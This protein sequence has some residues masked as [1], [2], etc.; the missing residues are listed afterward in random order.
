MPLSDVQ[1]LLELPCE[2]S[3]GTDI[4]RLARPHY[5]IQGFHCFLDRSFVI[6]AM[7]LIEINIICPKPL[8]ALVDLAQDRLSRQPGAIRPFTHFPMHFGG[9]DN[10]IPLSEVLQSTSENL[11]THPNRVNISR[12]K[13]IYPQ[14]KGFLDDWPAVF[15]IKHPFVNPTC[16]IPKPHTSQTEA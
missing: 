4:A 6:P 1:C 14:L 10:L 3:R 2:H 13:E 9:D 8:Q 5:I 15:L 12:I 11:L 16:R 7:D